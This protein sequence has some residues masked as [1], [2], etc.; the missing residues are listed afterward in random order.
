MKWVQHNLSCRDIVK[1]NYRMQV[2]WAKAHGDWGYVNDFKERAEASPLWQLRVEA[3]VQQ[4]I[5]SGLHIYN[6]LHSIWQNQ[7]VGSKAP[8]WADLD[9]LFPTP[10]MPL[11]LKAEGYQATEQRWD[12]E[13]SFSLSSTL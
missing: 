13:W 12:K 9:R 5:A 4:W 2:S 6:S 11:V 10:K 7:G 1:M 3:Q 8:W